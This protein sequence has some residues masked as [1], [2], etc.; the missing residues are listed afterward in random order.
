MCVQTSYVNRHFVLYK[1]FCICKSKFLFSFWACGQKISKYISLK[2]KVWK[3]HLWFKRE[4]TLKSKQF[5]CLLIRMWSIKNIN[6]SCSLLYFIRMK[7]KKKRVAKIFLIFRGFFELNKHS[8]RTLRPLVFFFS[9]CFVVKYDCSWNLWQMGE[10]WICEK[11]KQFLLKTVWH[12]A[13]PWPELIASR[14]VSGDDV[15]CATLEILWNSASKEKHLRNFGWNII[16]PF[17]QIL[18]FFWRLKN[19]TAPLTTVWTYCVLFSWVMGSKSI[20]GF[21]WL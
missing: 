16:F 12:R 15:T 20:W 1:I 17:Q 19:K 14:L 8:K 5:L 13:S 3:K 9:T 21:S 11:T 4:K 6:I 2:G 10:K 18:E 7:E